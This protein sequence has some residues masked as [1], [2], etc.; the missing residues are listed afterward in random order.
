MY[1]GTIV[2]ESLRDNRI[3]NNLKVIGVRV[4]NDDDPAKRWHLYKVAAD[5]SQI[6]KLADELKTEKWYM[7]FWDGDDI[8]AV[9]PGKTFR[10]EHSD[11]ASWEN[12]VNYGLLLGIPI[13]Q[14]DFVI[15]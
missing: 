8:I 13:E 3:L 4:S 5:E 10:F 11:K 2:E 6:N 12:A 9:F 7:H 1:M 14:L 15:E